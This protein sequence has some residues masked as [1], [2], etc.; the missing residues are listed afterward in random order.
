[1]TKKDQI[2]PA[3]WRN[4]LLSPSAI[5]ILLLLAGCLSSQDK[6][7][8]RIGLSKAGPGKHYQNYMD[9]LK[10]ADSTIEFVNFYSMGIDSAVKA[11]EDCDGFI[12]TGGPDVHPAWY[13]REQDTILCGA[14]DLRRDSLEF[15]L[16]EKALE[17]NIPILGICRGEQIFNVAMGGTLIADIPTQYDSSVSHRS[18]TDPYNNYHRVMIDSNSALYL[19]SKSLMGIVNSNHHQAVDSLGENLGVVARADDHLIEALEWNEKEGKPFLMLVQWHP[20]RM[21]KSNPLSLPIALYFLKAAE[22]FEKNNRLR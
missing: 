10:I 5:L 18:A 19:T 15:R 9:W 17:T 6:T 14:I 1:M 16:I 3:T 11:L 12:L 20:E 4:Q 22:S 7:P 21:D 13:G 2:Y 8:L